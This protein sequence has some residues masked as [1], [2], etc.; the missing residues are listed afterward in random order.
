MGNIEIDFGIA[1]DQDPHALQTAL[2]FARLA[3]L[4][5]RC[6]Y[7]HTDRKLNVERELAALVGLARTSPPIKVTS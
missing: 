1:G 3:T 7:L 4:R 6:G 5:F 2:R